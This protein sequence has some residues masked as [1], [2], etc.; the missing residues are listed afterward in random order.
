M[1]LLGMDVYQ[2]ELT[3][4]L[5]G[6]L[7]LSKNVVKLADN[8]YFGANS[9]E[10]FHEVFSIILKRVNESDLR[11]KPSK[12]SINIQ[13]SDILGLH[14]KKGKLSPSKHKLDPLAEC[15]PPKTVKGLRSWLGGV[16]FNEI[17][18]PGSKLAE[19]SKL[20][21]FNAAPDIP[22]HPP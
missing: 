9:L 16:R 3:D 18:L 10:E 19:L 22:T 5:F 20:S 14:W 1:G 15:D 2:D 17:C 13:S 7:V 21:E 12:V 4:R 11:I 6:D 8:I